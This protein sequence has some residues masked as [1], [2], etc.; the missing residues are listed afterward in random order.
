MLRIH[1]PVLQ[2]IFLQ[3][4]FVLQFRFSLNMVLVYS[5]LAL[6]VLM[7]RDNVKW[8]NSA[9][10][11]NVNHGGE[12]SQFLAEIA[13]RTNYVMIYILTQTNRQD[14]QNSNKQIGMTEDLNLFYKR[15]G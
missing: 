5:T 10:R 4:S 14:Q 6:H 1:S 11:E 12:L 7:Q 8:S 3:N 9:L 2:I 13:E 15:V